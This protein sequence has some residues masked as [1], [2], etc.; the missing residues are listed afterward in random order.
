MT[1]CVWAQLVGKQFS[2]L[3]FLYS[4]FYTLLT[5][6]PNPRS[7]SCWKH[8]TAKSRIRKLG[9]KTQHHKTKK[10]LI[11]LDVIIRYRSIFWFSTIQILMDFFVSYNCLYLHYS[12]NNK[13][14]Y[15]FFD[16]NIGNIISQSRDKNAYSQSDLAE[17]IKFWRKT[18]GKTFLDAFITKKKIQQ[19][20]L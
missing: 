17:K 12:I 7:L 15:L 8:L 14:F 11:F 19:L 3:Y 13:Y 20:A 16:M 6:N 4:I 2:I 1:N 9:W 5:I 18:F 10:I